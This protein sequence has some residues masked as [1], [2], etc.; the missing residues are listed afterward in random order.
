M[1]YK[2]LEQ[3][4]K[5]ICEIVETANTDSLNKAATR[6][7]LKASAF[8]EAYIETGGDIDEE[9]AE[10]Q[11]KFWESLGAAKGILLALNIPEAAFDEQPGSPVPEEAVSASSPRLYKGL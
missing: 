5:R 11:H 9:S 4:I 1:L 10:V 8:L 6:R 7:L 3:R 2:A